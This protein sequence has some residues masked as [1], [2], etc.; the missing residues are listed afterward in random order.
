MST[1]ARRFGLGAGVL[2][3]LAM[4]NGLT[5]PLSAALPPITVRGRF[6]CVSPAAER[7]GSCSSGR[8]GIRVAGGRVFIFLPND[9]A[10]A[11]YAD[12]RLRARELQVTALRHDGDR[13]ESIRV[14][15]IR[16]GRLYEI[17]YVCDV[18]QITSSVPGP[19]PCCQKALALVET[20]VTY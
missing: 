8:V 3:V 15:S 10:V 18:C 2:A 16:D 14:R 7:D 6:V 1:H 19:C 13:L 17:T 5:L 20:P 4:G 9:L 12:P 11:L